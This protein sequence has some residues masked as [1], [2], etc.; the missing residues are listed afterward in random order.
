MYTYTVRVFKKHTLFLFHNINKH[1]PTIMPIMKAPKMKAPPMEPPIMS[2]M[3]PPFVSA[4]NKQTSRAANL[5]CKQ[6]YVLTSFSRYQMI[7]AVARASHSYLASTT[8]NLN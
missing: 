8:D 4:K 3:K 5:V 6:M 2:P 1:T 7:R